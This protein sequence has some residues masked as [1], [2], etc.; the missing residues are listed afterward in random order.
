MF[1]LQSLFLTLPLLFKIHQLNKLFIIVLLYMFILQSLL[2]TLSLLF[3]IHQ[4][5]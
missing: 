4:M 2:L 5:L 3:K 1:I